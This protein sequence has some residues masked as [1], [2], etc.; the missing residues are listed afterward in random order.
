MIIMK[1]VDN[2]VLMHISLDSEDYVAIMLPHQLASLAPFGGEK[3][4]SH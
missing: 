2:V 4:G 3:V 1:M